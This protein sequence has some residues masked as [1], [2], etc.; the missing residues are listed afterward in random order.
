MLNR[1]KK[2]ADDVVFMFEMKVMLYWLHRVNGEGNRSNV[3]N[4]V[5]AYYNGS[6]TSKDNEDPGWNTSFKTRRTQKTTIDFEESFAPVARLE[7]VRMFI[8]YAAHKNIT[9]IQIVSPK[10]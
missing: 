3:V 2:G 8:A 7:A 6:R 9:I 5:H 1:D 4:P 10:I